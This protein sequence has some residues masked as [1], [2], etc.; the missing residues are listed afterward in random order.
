MLQAMKLVG[1]GREV[2]GYKIRFEKVGCVIEGVSMIRL[3]QGEAADDCRF[4]G[5][6]FFSLTSSCCSLLSSS[7][8]F[9][10]C[11]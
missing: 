6:I 10:R 11:L 3:C 5:W 8:K 1:V 4:E 2:K 7:F 9:T